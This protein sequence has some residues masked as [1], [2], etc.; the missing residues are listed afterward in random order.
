MAATQ[1]DLQFI[2]DPQ[3]YEA[4][5]PVA[6]LSALGEQTAVLW[7]QENELAHWPQGSG[8]WLVLRHAECM[9]EA[10]QVLLLLDIGFQ[11]DLLKGIELVLALVPHSPIEASAF[12]TI[13]PTHP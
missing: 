1:H 13:L 6:E 3:R 5:A 11:G 9:R 2:Y 4:G 10:L 7:V 8:F 12:G